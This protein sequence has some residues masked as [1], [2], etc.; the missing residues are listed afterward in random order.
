[1][2]RILIPGKDY[3]QGYLQSITRLTGELAKSDLNVTIH[4]SY[5]PYLPEVRNILLRGG[6]A[7]HGNVGPF[8]GNY[9]YIMWIETDIVF[10]P[11]NF[12]NLYKTALSN[13]LDV[14]TGLFP[15]NIHTPDYAVAG[16]SGGR[17][18]MTSTGLQEILYCGVGFMLVKKGVYERLSYPWYGMGKIYTFNEFEN[19]WQYN[20]DDFSTCYRMRE[21]G[22]K[23]YAD[24]DV[25]LGHEKPYIITGRENAR[26]QA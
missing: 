24:C 21:H 8:R 9:D 18:P 11:D 2:V 26:S 10:T 17:L 25:K 19:L 15:M 14:V 12:F 4:N 5:G 20:G 6:E 7:P 3:T 1:M 13:N 22:V 23:I 16:D